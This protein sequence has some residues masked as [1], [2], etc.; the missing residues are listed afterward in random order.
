MNTLTRFMRFCA[1]QASLALLFSATTAVLTFSACGGGGGSSPV[2]KGAFTLSG[3]SV[4]FSISQ[5]ETPP[6]PHTLTMTVTGSDV[7]YVGAGYANGQSQPE[8]LGVDVQP[9]GSTG[10]TFTVT[11]SINTTNT[12][13]GHYSTTFQVG[14]SDASG[15]ILQTQPVT[16]SLTVT[17]LSLVLSTDSPSFSALQGGTKPVDQ[18][19]VITVAKGAVQALGAVFPN[20]QPEWLGVQFSGSGA[21]FNLTLSVLNTNLAPGQYSST[22]YV[23]PIGGGWTTGIKPVTVSY[24]LAGPSLVL[25]TDSCSFS[26]LQ[27]ALNPAAQSIAIAVTRGEVQT[28]GAVFPNG[29]PGWLGVQFSG[30]GTSF[31]LTLSVL[32]TSLPSGQY[33]TTFSVGS[34]GPDGSLWSLK[35]VTVSFTLAEPSLVLSADSASFIALQNTPNPADQPIAVSVAGGELQALGAVFPNGQP[36]WLGLQFSGARASFSIAL[37]VLNV[38]LAPGQYSS[39]FSIGPRGT[40]GTVWPKKT[41]AVSFTVSERISIITPPVREAFTFGDSRSSSTIPLAVRGLGRPWTLRSDVAWLQV[42]VPA[43]GTGDATV[44]VRLDASQLTPGAYAGRLTLTNPNDPLDTASIP[45]SVDMAPPVLTLVQGAF[46][47][48]GADGLAPLGQLPLDIYLST[49]QTAHPFSVSL[50]TNGSGDWLTA[51]RKTGTVGLS[52]TRLKIGVDRSQV[53]GGFHRGEIRVTATVNGLTY[54]EVRPV[55]LTLE[56]NRLVVETRGIG[57]SARPDRSVLSR[58]VRV[59]SSVQRTDVPWA[60]HSDQ[61]WLQV[62]PAGTTG[63]ALIITADP[64]G[65]SGETT[66][67]ATVTITSPDASVENQQEIRVGLHVTS[68]MPIQ[69]TQSV[70]ARHLAASP[71]EPLVAVSD[72]SPTLRFYN[73]LSGAL[74]RTLATDSVCLNA[75]VFSGDGRTLFALDTAQVKILALDPETGARTAIYDSGNLGS[76]SSDARPLA[77]ICPT[78]RAVLIAP[79]G[80]AFDL[81]SGAPFTGLQPILDWSLSLAVSPDQSLLANDGGVVLRLTRS[82]LNGDGLSIQNLGTFGGGGFDGQTCFSASGDRL[83]SA[84]GWPYEFS[85]RSLATGEVIQHLPGDAYPNS[86]S[87]CWN[88]LVVGGIMGHYSEQDIWIY[89]GPSGAL[90]GQLSSSAASGAQRDLLPRGLALSADGTRVV[91]AWAAHPAEYSAIGIAFQD[92]PAPR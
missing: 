66:H 83:Y 9:T 67:F 64:S 20:G 52:G 92:L 39:T 25:A 4:S 36:G 87:S 30:A 63:N 6:A 40:D 57:L 24:T 22:F 33:S 2:A 76:T 27:G 19:I 62:T 37:S 47:F 73:I 85:A 5:Y 65:L 51:D 59:F 44:E 35:P 42:P 12:A 53:R 45:V 60:A 91:S 14:T 56:A 81:E 49:G 32:N 78:G 31:S 16:V 71:T 17:E 3:N 61:A 86:I 70:A 80:R 11:V 26:A 68:Q 88:G 46:S 74:V 8:W 50:S 54:T 48:G 29:Q 89:D 58:S 77:Y 72:G 23:G 34:R 1:K 18:S 10:N 15:N 43:D 55:S 7:R 28:L 13:P 21:S 79:S 75:L 38:G 90:L 84:S 82:A 69:A 41:V